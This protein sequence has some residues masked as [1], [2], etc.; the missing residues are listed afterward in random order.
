[1]ANVIK[2]PQLPW[3]NPQELV[4]PIPD[5]WQI[6]TANMA[7]YDRPA[8]TD[9]QIRDAILN[10]IGLPPIREAARG[11][12]EVVIIFD[13]ITRVTRV[14]R[15]IPYLL[16]ELAAA[17]IPDSNIRFIVAAGLHGAMD[18]IQ[19]VKKLGESVLA[20]FPVYNHNPFYNCTYVGTT[21]RGTEVHINSEYIKCDFKIAIGSITPHSFAVF[22]GGSKMILPGI[23]SL[24][25]IVHNHDIQTDSEGKVNYEKNAI[26]LDMDEAA[27]FVGMDVNIEGLINLWGDTVELFVGEHKQS[28]AIGIKA[29]APHYVTKRAQNK[30]IVIA[31]AY[32]KLTESTNG[33]K[34]AF[35]SVKK[36]G[37]DV[38]LIN[39]APTGQSHHYVLGPC[40]KM[41]TSMR[42]IK[43]RVPENVN[44]LIVFTEY[45]D[46]AGLDYIE[47]S[48]K[49]M[50]LTKW[51][52]V[53]KV[54]QEAHGDRAEVAVY[55]NADIQ[56]FQP[57]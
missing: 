30:D 28:H 20:R 46:Y 55:P 26:H 21:S 19:F 8:I 49:V 15:I 44:R 50:M 23:A 36:D 11:K 18:R 25:T 52:E 48:P 31:N 40:G 14:Y 34:T 56:S 42:S 9:E 5:N 4:L 2:L 37:G 35:P 17:G 51:D 27:D 12:K 43:S 29:A 47:A 54:L 53:I 33:L 38:V 10:P 13:D 7:G 32:A 57:S 45:P 3:D 24:E 6:E 1:M 41:I 16:E 39:N 22:S